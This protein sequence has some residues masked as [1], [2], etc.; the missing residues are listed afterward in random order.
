MTTK[1]L[2]NTTITMDQILSLVPEFKRQVLRNLSK[3]EEQVDE[4][5]ACQIEAEEVE[6]KVSKITVNFQE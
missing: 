3:E 1:V 2:R 5:E 4:P 6:Y